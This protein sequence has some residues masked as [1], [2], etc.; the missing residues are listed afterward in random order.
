[1]AHHRRVTAD[2]PRHVDEFAAS[3][4]VIPVTAHLERLRS[5]DRRGFDTSTGR[6]VL[7]RAHVLGHARFA[8]D[9]RGIME[10]WQ[11]ITPWLREAFREHWLPL[12][13][14]VAPIMLAVGVW[15][16][17]PWWFAL[18]LVV[19]VTA[20]IVGYMLRPRHIW[21]MWAG[22]VVTQWVAMGIF[23]RY[24]NAGPDETATSLV[25]EALIYMALGVALPLWLGRIVSTNVERPMRG[26]NHRP[27]GLAQ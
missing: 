23:D 5:V 22:A 14:M 11:R 4:A 15:T 17:E 25:L 9:W 27:R 6:C 26:D 1:M 18:I 10:I 19:P 12:L 7:R 13:I 8:I 16:S 21:I 2:Q 20:A 3:V 24:A